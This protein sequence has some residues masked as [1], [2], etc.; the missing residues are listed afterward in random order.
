[1]DELTTLVMNGV[2]NDGTV[3]ID[4]LQIILK[5]L[6]EQKKTL[7]E[8]IK[9]EQK[10][11]TTLEREAA[12]KIG[13]AYYNS[14]NVGDEFYYVSASG[15]E[16]AAIKIDTKTKTKST[17]ACELVNPPANAKTAKRYPRFWQVKVPAEFSIEEVA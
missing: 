16:F 4:R 3:D 7:K 8:Q 17:A 11:K 2:V 9:K 10:D 15:E 1:M 14:L 6:N 5:E 12:G 13:L